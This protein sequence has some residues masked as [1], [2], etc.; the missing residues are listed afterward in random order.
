MYIFVN[1][2]E[3]SNQLQMTTASSPLKK[4]SAS[5]TYRRTLLQRGSLFHELSAHVE[6]EVESARATTAGD[7]ADELDRVNAL[8][9]LEVKK[10][11]K[12]QQALRTRDAAELF[13]IRAKYQRA[14]DRV[15]DL[16]VL[17]AFYTP[18]SPPHTIFSYPTT[19]VQPKTPVSCQRFRDFPWDIQLKPIPVLNMSDMHTI[20]ANGVK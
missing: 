17:V 5:E 20:A 8:Y 10:V 15:K 16:E 4:R 6:Q 14:V 12:L 11:D 9:E 1:Y 13:C 7:L 19:T 3:L 2:Q 18:K